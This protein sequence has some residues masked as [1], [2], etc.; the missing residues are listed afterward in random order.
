MTTMQ[1]ALVADREAVP[2]TADVEKRLAA[3]GHTV[4][5]PRGFEFNDG[6]HAGWRPITLNG[7]KTG[8]DYGLFTV[9]SMAEEDPSTAAKLNGIGSHFLDFGA[10]GQESGRAVTVVLRAICELSGASGWAADEVIP[11]DEMSQFLAGKEERAPDAASAAKQRFQPSHRRAEVPDGGLLL[12][13]A[14]NNQALA[15]ADLLFDRDQVADQ[16]RRHRLSTAFQIRTVP[17]I[18]SP[19]LAQAVQVRALDA[20]RPLELFEFAITGS[21]Q[22]LDRAVLADQ[23]QVGCGRALRAAS[24]GCL[25]ALRLRLGFDFGLRQY[26]P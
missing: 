9:A 10:R 4:R 17:L 1:C 21:L 20:D 11:A 15:I 12:R 22:F 6:G 7:T 18:G 8:F 5:F 16:R 25:P 24:Q 2:A 3:Y 19:L 26:P 13:G 23:F 14:R